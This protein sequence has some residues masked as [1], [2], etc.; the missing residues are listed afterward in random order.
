MTINTSEKWKSK[1]LLFIISQC[2]TLF[3]SSLVQFAII[4]YV[5][6]ET[7][8]GIWMTVLTLC[9]YLP[10]MLISFFAGV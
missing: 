3:G 5:T 10:Q 2:I 7:S 1:T 9:S 8:S 4:W 6:F